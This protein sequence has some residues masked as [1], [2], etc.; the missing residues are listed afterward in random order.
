MI[1]SRIY[2]DLGTANTLICGK[3]DSP[4]VNEPSFVA[5]RTSEY[6]QDGQFYSSGLQAKK[7]LGRTH[8]RLN[9]VRP[10]QDGVICNLTATSDMLRDF[11]SRLEPRMGKM[12]FII[13]LPAGVTYSEREAVRLAGVQSGARRV[14]IVSETMMAALGEGLDIFTPQAHFLVDI[15]GGTT[16]V[17]LIA[18][19]EIVC[20]E[21]VRYGGDGINRHIVDLVEQ[22]YG[23]DIGEQTAEDLKLKHA[24][25]LHW[26][27]EMIQ[28]KGKEILTG[29]PKSREIS[30]QIIHAA[31]EKF[32]GR[33]I[34]AAR[35]CM[36]KVP[37]E[38]ASDIL[39]Q[40]I[41]VTGGGALIRNLAKRLSKN[42]GLTVNV[43]Q[44]PLSSA[45]R[46]GIQVVRDRQLLAKLEIV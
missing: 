46:G 27:E 42:L 24:D 2:I 9:V 31:T 14:R 13:S 18:L 4:L 11:M 16:E 6:H 21:V 5:F 39:D 38:W 34:E 32:I 41:T 35:L 12:E 26:R 43:A 20:S 15:G 7:M 37:P 25:A 45:A 30:T 29:M 36:N 44:D 28:V 33:L 3:D 1:T 19:G 17:V 23:F 10:L 22:S 40:G 8:D